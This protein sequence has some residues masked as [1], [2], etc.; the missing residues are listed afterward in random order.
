MSREDEE[1]QNRIESCEDEADLVVN[2]QSHSSAYVIPIIIFFAVIYFLINL[3]SENKAAVQ[4]FTDSVTSKIV[5]P[6]KLALDI[7]SKEV[8][9]HQIIPK[10]EIGDIKQALLTNRETINDVINGMTPMMLAASRGNVDIIDLL[11]TQGADPNKR[12]SMERTALQ[13]A[14]EKNHIE[15][16]KR[17]LDYGADIDACD[18]GRLT[19][20]VMAASRGYTELSL[21]LVEKGADVNIQHIKGWTALI[22][23][24]AHNDVKLVKALLLA[25]ANKELKAKNGLSAIDYARQY[26][27]KNIEKILSK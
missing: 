22:D 21:L 7:V 16:V 9:L 24:T 19:P 26:G 13:Y 11:F 14:V 8:K 3:Y 27:F 17:L 2:R 12:G 6:E 1:I 5:I 23:A 10:G 4:S 18:N 20:L 25:G 15:A